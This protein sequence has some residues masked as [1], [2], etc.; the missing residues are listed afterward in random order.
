MKST[1]SIY[2]VEDEFIYRDKVEELLLNFPKRELFNYQIVP[3]TSPIAFYKQLDTMTIHDNDLFILDIDLNTYFS[4]IDLG[5][6]IRGLNENCFIIFLTNLDSKGIEVINANVQPF[7]YI[8]KA[9]PHEKLDTQQIIEDL[10]Y[11]IEAAILE[12][13]NDDDRF[14]V[15]SNKNRQLLIPYKKIV[16]ISSV[17]QSRGQVLIKT[18]EEEFYVTSSLKE[19]KKL[20]KPDYFYKELRSHILNVTM[21]TSIDRSSETISFTDGHLLHVGIRIIEK[22]QKFIY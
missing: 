22:L 19:L 20:L 4:G 15:V 12:R 11:S 10:F 13:T 14:L 8:L 1:V 16:Y 18:I 9:L 17:K 21:V 2:I 5:K 6:Q 3:V 7:S